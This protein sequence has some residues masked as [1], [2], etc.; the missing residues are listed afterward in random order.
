MASSRQLNMELLLMVGNL[1]VYQAMPLTLSGFAQALAFS[2]GYNG[3]YI[4]LGRDIL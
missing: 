4:P 1:Q 2:V 3:S